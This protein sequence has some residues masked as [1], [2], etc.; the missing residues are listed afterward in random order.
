[1]RALFRK[2]RITIRT[3][4]RAILLS[5]LGWVL[6]VLLWQSESSLPLLHAQQ[7]EVAQLQAVVD[8]LQDGIATINAE[9]KAFVTD[10]YMLEKLAREQLGMGKAGETV[11]VLG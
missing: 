5:G 7:Q 4:V 8:D 1:M 6:C 2:K 11:Y 9:M 10:E 3:L